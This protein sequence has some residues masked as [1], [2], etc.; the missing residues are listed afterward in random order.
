MGFVDETQLDPIPGVDSQPIGV[1]RLISEDELDP[2]GDQRS[3]YDMLGSGTPTQQKARM[4]VGGLS[5]IIPGIGDEMVAAG[6][7]LV[8]AVRGEGLSD[9]YNR[10][11]SEVRN[12][13]DAFDK[14]L[15]DASGV[16]S[17]FQKVGP[18]LLMPVGNAAKAVSSLKAKALVS[19]LEGGTV[20]AGLGF[21]DGRGEEDRIA[22]AKFGGTVGAVVSPIATTA[23]GLAGKAAPVLD[24]AS[25]SLNRSSIRARF[26]DYAK[27][28][29][30]IGLIDVPGGNLE[31]FTKQ[32]I[33]KSLKAD[34]FGKTRDFG[35]MAS[36]LNRESRDLSTQIDDVIQGYGGTVKPT[37]QHSLDFLETGKVPADKI[38]SYLKRLGEIESKINTEGK[39]A[40]PYIQQQK[41]AFGKMFDPN[42][43]ALTEFNRRIY[44][45]LQETIE[46]AVPKV[47]GLNNTLRELK[48]IEPILKRGIAGEESGNAVKSV[49]Q[50]IRTSGGFGVP[51][52]AGV[53]TGNPIA[54]ALAGVAG[55]YSQTP[56]GMAQG[57][58]LLSGAADKAA[59]FSNSGLDATA[60]KALVSGLLP[61][62]ANVQQE[63]GGSAQYQR[64]SG[65]GRQEEKPTSLP[66]LSQIQ[67]S[68]ALQSS[69]QTSN[70]SLPFSK[71][72]T[73]KLLNALRKVES[74]DNS[75][76]VS[77]KGAQGPYQ[78]M[79]STA[80]EFGLKD[81]FNES[82]SRIAAEKK[83][84]TD[85]NKFKDL[86]LTLA[87]YNAGSG[88]VEKLLKKTGGNSFDD[89]DELLPKET[90]DY[91]AKIAKVLS[92]A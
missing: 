73:E 72:S 6:T 19:A 79:P 53:G 89:I 40:L 46:S 26:G 15:S 52:L 76:A 28:A 42:D 35:K 34:R 5:Q 62:S 70:I 29:N 31:T 47:K 56:G 55:A 59:K 54:G 22:K 23:L 33:D 7:S 85:F 67:N 17:T 41:V 63:S 88:R 36:A 86:A 44:R 21:A 81:P 61:S 24:D 9:A 45:D 87:A 65:P 71:E 58:R 13:Q 82:E 14:R 39:G 75:K 83:L 64:S 66:N 16:V 50:N 90:R 38:D 8:D 68:K 11:L 12:Y 2:I 51:F 80:K 10:R 74:N 43:G 69:K 30:E 20:G 32:A 84:A 1:G 25:G 37:F 92:R 27:D 91:V 77:S 78:F 49:M 60:L 4:L 57:A 48:V 3:V 18:A